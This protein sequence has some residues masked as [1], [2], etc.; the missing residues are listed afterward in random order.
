MK[1][2]ILSKK[3]TL[4]ICLIVI[5]FLFVITKRIGDT[6]SVTPAIR[7]VYMHYPNYEITVLALICAPL[8]KV[9]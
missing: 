5:K 3:F 2:Q 7:S 8:K 9:V 6:M 4:E 1:F